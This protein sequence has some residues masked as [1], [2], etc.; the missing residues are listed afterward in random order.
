MF[1]NW[2]TNGNNDYITCFNY[3]KYVEQAIHSVLEQNFNDFELII[4]DD[5]SED[6][7]RQIIER[8]KTHPKVKIIFQNNKGLNRSNNV[9]VK[10]ASGDYIIRLDAD[11]YLDPNAL[12]FLTKKIE[13]K[14][15]CALVFP[16]YFLVD[17]EGRILSQ[18]RRHNFDQD[19]EIYDQPAHGAC[20][21]FRKSVLK[22]IGMYSEKYDRQ[23]GYE[24]WTKITNKYDVTNVNLPL[25]YYR[26]HE[27]SLT[28]NEDQLLLTRSEILL[29]LSEESSNP[30]TLAIIPI[31]KDSNDP[32]TA[33]RAFSESN[34]LEMLILKLQSSRRINEI[35]VSTNDQSVV[36]YLEKKNYSGIT[37]HKRDD[38][39]S[40]INT[41]LELT[42][43]D[44]LDFY[45]N[46]IETTKFFTILHYE[47]PFLDISN[48]E[49]SLNIMSIYNANSSMSVLACD[50]NFYEHDGRGL[51]PLSNNSKLR[52]ERDQIFQEIGGIHS[53]R[54]DWYL[55]NPSLQS[56]KSTHLIID[57]LSSKKIKSEE[58]FISLEFLFRKRQ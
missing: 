20:T 47:Y 49:N 11:D 43:N 37:I 39:I 12:H 46:F 33:I 51:Q 23:D 4:I 55:N 29:N 19:V 41:P 42:V 13:E 1:I 17:E 9:A 16:D 15:S 32:S 5:G 38:S 31:R 6:E 7:S 56:D 3:G 21:M 10:I 30:D 52:L 57:Y 18:E 14:P 58:D 45:P 2:R 48:I 24:I 25:F 53:F 35:V 28:G 40:A 50:T 27:K 54:L 34:L 44:I 8:F 22:E 26:Q 36:D